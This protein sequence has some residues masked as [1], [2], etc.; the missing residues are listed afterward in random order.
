MDDAAAGGHPVDRT[1][2][3]CLHRAE[4]VAVND[5]AFEQVGDGG[6]TDVRMR[7]DVDALTGG[8]IG[9]A[10]V[11]E[12]DERPDHSPHRRRQDPPHD[13]AAE[14]ALPPWMRPRSPTSPGVLPGRRCQGT[15]LLPPTLPDPPAPAWFR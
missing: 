3:D 15:A 7:A 14:I 11:V 8:E 4:A 1:R 6:E 9:R 2:P 13:E 5:L 12:E 10:H